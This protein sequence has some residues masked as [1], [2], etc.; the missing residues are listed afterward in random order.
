MADY[1]VIPQ[2][3]GTT[4]VSD[5][6]TIVEKADSG[7]PRLRSFYTSVRHTF[8][9][10]H[11]VDGTDKDLVAAHYVTDQFLV[12]NFTFKAD[13]TVHSCRYARAPLEEPIPGTDRWKVSVQLVVV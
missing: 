2:V 13:S 4:R 9:V 3:F 7:K 12:F 1:P 8:N 6:G 10:I 11:D 5:D